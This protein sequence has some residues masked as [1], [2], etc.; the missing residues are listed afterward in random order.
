[1][2]KKWRLC[3][4]VTA[5]LTALSPA[6]SASQTIRVCTYENFPLTFRDAEGQASGLFHDILREIAL[7]ESWTLQYR[8]DSWENCLQALKDGDVDVLPA[9]GENPERARLCRFGRETVLVNWGVLITAQGRGVQNIIELDGKRI[10]VGI[11]DVYAP[12]LVELLH[13]FQLK[14]EY[15]QVASYDAVLSMVES[16]LAHAGL[17]SRTYATFAQRRS[18]TM[19]TPIVVHPVE[20]KFATSLKAAPGLVDTIDGHLRIWK[21]DG[22]SPFH[23]A[24]LRWLLVSK[25]PS[26]H[27]VLP[28]YFYAALAVIAILAAIIFFM[29]S[30][31]RVMIR[32]V[33]EAHGRLDDAATKKR[34]AESALAEA[35]RWDRAIFEKA[36]DALMILDEKGIILQCNP[37]A[38]RLFNAPQE[39]IVGKKPIDFSPG[40][41][42]DGSLS[43]RKGAVFLESTLAGCSQR[44]EWMHETLDG[45]TFSAEVQ[46]S[47]MFQA[48]QPRILAC[49][50]DVSHKMA[51]EME[52]ERQREYL[53]TVLDG[54]PIALFV[55]DLEGRVVFWNAMCERITGMSQ[56]E[57]LGRPLNLKSILEGKD[58]PIPALLLLQM[59]AKEFLQRHRE[60]KAQPLPFHAE[61][62]QLTGKIVVQGQQRHMSIVVTRLRDRQGE[63]LGVV[64][65]ARDITQEIQMHKQLVHSQKMEA[66][67]KLSAGIAHDFNN[68]LTIILGC[69]DL[70]GKKSSLDSATRKRV[71]EIKKAAERP[72]NLTRPLLVFSRKQLMQ[73]VAL[74][75]NK[76]VQDL[77]PILRR[78]VGEDIE[79]RLNLGKDLWPVM[80]DSVFLEQ[81][82][83]NLVINA[84]DAMPLGGRITIET[85]NEP[86]CEDRDAG[87]F[88]I[89]SGD[90]VCFRVRDTGHGIDPEIQQRIF[91]PFFTTKPEG[92]GTGLGLATVYGIVKQLEGYILVDSAVGQGAAFQIFLPRSTAQ[93]KIS[94]A[95]ST[96]VCEVPPGSETILVVED[97][98]ALREMLLDVLSENGYDVVTAVSGAEALEVLEGMP[99]VDLVVTDV[100]MPEMNGAALS[101]Q[102]AEKAPRLPVLFIS[103]YTDDQLAH[104]G[105]LMPDVHFLTKPFSP[106][107]LLETVRRILHRETHGPIMRANNQGRPM[108][109]RP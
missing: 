84:R 57:V 62:I 22:N 21:A 76:L 82:L 4:L 54:I 13:R 106:E 18:G 15:V 96:Q 109:G 43:H 41:Q 79:I 42:P 20:L 53:Q 65:C 73:P 95:S 44:F 40:V 77:S 2:G 80:A 19:M 85:W 74:D 97:E 83:L 60:W 37:A 55:I 88:V 58:L 52:R 71:G 100:V 49:V 81:T 31:L 63:L 107:K 23:Q 3:L 108:K 67:G 36:D 28:T 70:I 32:R 27:G 46:L 91:E 35:E 66:V 59:T 39:H 69:C 78:A 56:K 51:V 90:Y 94:P 38:S 29:R 26:G 9:T 47:L 6:L 50:R 33:Q 99:K 11:E 75:L 7:R 34:V 104:R 16:G 1:M 14:V 92:R 103:G 10:A 12:A 87:L 48:D 105:I 45:K 25:E 93:E 98:E 24:M 61:G 30:Q 72:A 89:R 86:L 101:R 102:L 17:T 5:L 64:Q 8:H 68:I